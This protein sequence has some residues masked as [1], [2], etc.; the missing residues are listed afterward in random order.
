[1]LDARLLL[2][3][4]E[5]AAQL[6]KNMKVASGAFDIDEYLA[7][8]AGFI[9]GKLV[10][11][12]GAGHEADEVEEEDVEAW[13]WDRLGRAAGRCTKRAPVMDCLSVCFASHATISNT[14]MP[15]LPALLRP[16]R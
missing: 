8:I 1:V 4:S 13:Q 7:R 10:Q 2:N 6:A 11:P 5:T 16:P 15:V 12:G 9:G 14:G 3:T